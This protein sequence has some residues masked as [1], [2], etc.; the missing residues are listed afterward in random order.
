MAFW[1]SAALLNTFGRGSHSQEPFQ[2]TG[3]GRLFLEPAATDLARQQQSQGTAASPRGSSAP[4]RGGGCGPEAG[5]MPWPP[6]VPGHVSSAPRW[7][8]RRVS[9]RCSSSLA[10]LRGPSLHARRG[11][12]IASAPMGTYEPVPGAAGASIPLGATAPR[13]G[14]TSVPAGTPGPGG[15]CFA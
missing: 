3:L 8:F 12:R 13:R 14:S 15:S 2:R 5:A 6:P 7:C 10:L 4:R 11:Q 1:L 9:C